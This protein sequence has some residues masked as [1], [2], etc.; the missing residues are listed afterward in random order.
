MASAAATDAPAADAAATDDDDDAELQ[1]LASAR[2]RAPLRWGWWLV[3]A[4]IAAAAFGWWLAS[5]A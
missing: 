3:P 2:L 1:G 5:R 4:A